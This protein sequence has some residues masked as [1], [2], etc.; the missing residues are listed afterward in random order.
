M[1]KRVE[2]VRTMTS[3]SS[4]ASH[5]TSRNIHIITFSVVE[6]CGRVASGA[7]RAEKGIRETHNDT[8]RFAWL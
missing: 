4:S 2:S 8:E 5:Q 3:G 7:L 6:E 1:V